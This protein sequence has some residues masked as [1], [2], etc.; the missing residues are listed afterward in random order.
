MHGD[1]PSSPAAIH[2]AF[3]P[4][5]SCVVIVQCSADAEEVFP[6]TAVVHGAASAP[7]NSPLAPRKSSQGIYCACFLYDNG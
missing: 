6:G 4:S 5:F 7:G 3:L 2:L 1:E